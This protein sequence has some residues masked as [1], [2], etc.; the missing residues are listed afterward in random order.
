MGTLD[1]GGSEFPSKGLAFF[2]ASR[3]HETDLVKKLYM[4]RPIPEGFNLVEEMVRR[5]RSG[6]IDLTPTASSGWYDYQTWAL[7]PLVAPEQTAEAARLKLE[8]SYRKQLDELFKG[9]LALT[10]ETHVKQLEIPDAGGE[11]PRRWSGACHDSYRPGALGRTAGQLL[12]APRWPRIDLCDLPSRRRS[13]PRRCARCIVKRRIGRSP[14]RLADE[15]DQM[16][17]IFQGAA[18]TVLS[19]LGVAVAGPA[20]AETAAGRS[21]SSDRESFRRWAAAMKTDPDIG[22][23]ARMMVPVFFDRGRRKT[24]VWAF[25]G[26]S[27][28]PV[29]FWFATPPG[30]QVTR[31]GKQAAADQAVVEFGNAHQSLAYPVTAEVYVEK[32]LDRNEFRRHCDRY[33]T[34]SEILKNLH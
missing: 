3:A 11:S 18:A 33:K 7:E 23:D 15:I 31:D 1:A 21:A 12:R 28:R 24:K 17:A 10:R 25:L 4:D 16:E 8:E 6:K 9:I 30:V 19:E 27:Q 2:P 14:L 26:W 22:R 20:K 34:R 13:G 32:I 29:N 5:I